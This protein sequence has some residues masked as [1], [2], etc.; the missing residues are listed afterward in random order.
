[1]KE[2]TMRSMN[3]R[4]NW[5][6]LA[7]AAAIVMLVG[8]QAAAIRTLA[9]LKPAV[10]ATVDLE[11]AFNHLEKY[12]HLH[13]ELETLENQFL[14]EFDAKRR[15]IRMLEQDLDDFEPG[16]DKHREAEE[17]L[18]RLA[19]EYDADVEWSERLLN[20]RKAQAI[21]GVFRSIR[22]HMA[23]VARQRGIDIVLVDDAGIDL[24]PS[25]VAEGAIRQIAARRLLYTSPAV[26]ITDDVIRSMNQEFAA[27]RAQ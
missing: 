17:A 25:D 3:I 12:Q 20:F 7:L 14:K 27:E 13:R 1:M 16:H 21:E 18:V 10:V 11:K 15:R 2:Q 23:T 24:E 9:Q 19:L 22:E 8:Y 5:P 26:D 6:V 4:R